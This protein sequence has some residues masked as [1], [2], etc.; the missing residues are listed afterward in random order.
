MARIEGKVTKI[1]IE[2]NNQATVAIAGTMGGAQKTVDDWIFDVA[3]HPAWAEMLVEAR[4]SGRTIAV[5][6]VNGLIWM[7][8]E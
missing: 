7:V 1:K 3:V 8:E 4:R 6:D 2:S 5:Q